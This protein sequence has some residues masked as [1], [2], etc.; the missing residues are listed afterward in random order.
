MCRL[1]SL[2]PVAAAMALSVRAA[3]AAAI[4]G[5]APIVAA[6][7]VALPKLLMAAVI[8]EPRNRLGRTA[9]MH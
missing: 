7:V 3:A 1:N 5:E 9:H 4:E 6:A 2:S 8:R